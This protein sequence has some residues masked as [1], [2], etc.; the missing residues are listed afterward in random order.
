MLAPASPGPAG[1]ARRPATGV[2]TRASAARSLARQHLIDAGR[3][4]PIDP[5]TD[6]RVGLRVDV[7]EQRLVARLGDAGGDVDGGRRLADAALL[8]RDR[9]DGAHPPETLAAH[10]D[11]RGGHRRKVRATYGLRL[12]VQPP[13]GRRAATPS[14]RGNRA[15]VVARPSRRRADGASARPRTGRQRGPRT[16]RSP[17]SRRGPR[18]AGLL[19]EVARPAPFDERA[20]RGPAAA[21]RTRARAA[22]R[23]A[24]G[25]RR[26]RAR[27]A[28]PATT[29]HAGRRHG[30]LPSSIAAT[31]VGDVGALAP[32]G[33]H[34]THLEPRE[35]GGE[36]QARQSGSRTQIGADG[37]R[38]VRRAAPGPRASP[39]CAGRVRR[40]RPRCSSGPARRA[41]SRARSVARRAVAAGLRS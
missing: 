37:A 25:Q 16:G 18:G 41:P 13:S 3:A 8:V 29:P 6:G 10:G 23:P 12:A 11:G 26:D 39:R 17:S 2:A 14:R 34:Q 36:H 21:R 31:R 7:D 19:V 27:R 9:V 32:L 24:R 22:A 38:L 40:R 35:R 28:P 1:I 4:G 15:G 5:E 30:V 20:R 33:L